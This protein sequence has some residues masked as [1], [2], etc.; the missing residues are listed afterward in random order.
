M[1][2]KEGFYAALLKFLR[3]ELGKSDAVEVTGFHSEREERGYCETCAYSTTVIVIN[4]RTEGG[5]FV[6]TAEWEGEFA[7][8]ISR[9][10]E[11]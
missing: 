3:E 7:E 4:Y 2:W 11:K 1:S 8:L 10:E 6:E 5:R 9:L